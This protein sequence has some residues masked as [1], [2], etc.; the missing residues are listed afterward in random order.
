MRFRERLTAYQ[1]RR[2]MTPLIATIHDQGDL[3]LGE[4]QRLCPGGASSPEP[5]GFST[6]SRTSRDGR[7]HRV[8]MHRPKPRGAP[9]RPDS[10]AT[11]P[12]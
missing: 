12:L 2:K 4:D 3:M 7:D 5:A 1:R 6:R 11:R 10:G 8:R 9:L